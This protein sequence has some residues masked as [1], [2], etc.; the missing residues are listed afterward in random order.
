MRFPFANELITGGSGAAFRLNLP[1]NAAQKSAAE[2]MTAIVFFEIPPE[3]HE[4]SYRRILLARNN[5][6]TGSGDCYLRV[7]ANTNP[8]D[9]TYQVKTGTTVHA[10]GTISGLPV[11]KKFVALVIINPTAVHIAVAACDGSYYDDASHATTGAY[12]NAMTSPGM[13]DKIGSGLSTSRPWYGPLENVTFISGTFPEVTGAPDQSLV[14]AIA[15]GSQ[16]L[17]TLHTLFTSGAKDSRYP[18]LTS[19]DLSDVWELATALTKANEDVAGGRKA[20][21]AGPVRPMGL[22][23]ARVG[24]QISQ[25]IFGTVGDISTAAATV[26]VEGGVISMARYPT[27]TVVKAR[28]VGLD[29]GTVWRDWTPLTTN[30]GAGTWAAANFAN[31]PAKAEFMSLQFAG[32]DATDSMITRII[33]SS[34]IRGVGFNHIFSSQSQGMQYYETGGQAVASGLNL[35]TTIQHGT[36]NDGV[37]SD[38]FTYPRVITPYLNTGVGIAR[39]MVRAA[40]EINA[41]FPGYPIQFL[42]VGKAGV[43]VGKMTPISVANVNDGTDY[44]F[45]RW[46]HLATHLG[47]IP[48]YYLQL[49]GHSSGSD[50]SYRILFEEMRAEAVSHLGDPI[51]TLTIDVPRY[52]EAGTGSN[53]TQVQ[54]ARRQVREWVEDN[55]SL[56]YHGPSMAVVKTNE[57]GS[58]NP[59]PAN[60]D[61]G[62]GRGGSL[63]AWQIMMACRAVED[64]VIAPV[65]AR[66]VAATGRLYVE[67][68]AIN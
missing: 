33:C 10:T 41:L 15:D 26:R 14:E 47:V 63:L 68:G 22:T 49:M 21:P 30:T 20:F 5:G 48:P 16:S 55:P 35:M 24:D 36:I 54:N 52:S 7:K 27:L 39:G 37:E 50:S 59:H 43:G 51:K 34:G 56:G 62:Q 17:D 44:Y 1:A 40:E 42:T 18:M 66:T 2:A 11:G 25:C 9:L 31:V 28:L 67:L 58:S 32:F 13:F 4:D 61:E 8:I 6:T 38:V 65:A 64:V 46:A 3:F 45:N 12:D 29:T 19:T 23:P 57:T 53:F 60:T